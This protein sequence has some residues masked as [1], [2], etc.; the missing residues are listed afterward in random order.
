MGRR[1]KVTSA[2]RI[3]RERQVAEILALR[4]SGWSL[5]EIGESLHPAISAQ[6]VHK[7]I[8]KAIA[9]MVDEAVEQIRKIESLR[10][11]EATAAIYP[12]ASMGDLA[13]IDRLLSIMARRARL[14]GLDVRPVALASDGYSPDTPTAI[15]IV[16]NP[17]IERIR[18]LEAALEEGGPPPRVTSLPN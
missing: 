16:N 7:C 9:R 8:C 6:A 5:R 13:A 4:V 14:L 17:D 11:D 12:A 3:E 1:A 15:E 10:L 2:N 18:W